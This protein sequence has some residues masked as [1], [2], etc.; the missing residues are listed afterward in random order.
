MKES[1]ENRLPEPNMRLYFLLLVV[2]AICAIPVNWVLGLVQGAAAA[3]L[4]VV[5][6]RDQHRRR[7]KVLQYIDS[8]TGTVNNASKSNLVH[9]PLP[10]M[11]FRPDTGDVI[12]SNEEFLTA[13]GLREQLFEK[14]I[15]SAVPGFPVQWL[16]EGKR[17]CPERVV[18]QGRRFRV[19]GNLVRSRNRSGE[20]SLA[21]TTYWIDVT[22]ADALRET[23]DATRPVL[24]ILVIDNYEDVMKA[25]PESQRSALLAQFE[26]Q[27]NKWAEG[28]LLLRTQRDRYLCLFDER[29][30]QRF[31]ADKFSVMDTIREIKTGDSVSPTLSIGVGKD[32]D[33]IPE[34]YKYANLSLEMAL[35]RGGDQTVVRNKVDFDFFG[36]RAR[37]TEKRTKVKSRVMA[38]A[39]AE[40]MSDAE[41]VYVMGHSYS[42]MD[43]VGAAA[44]VCCAARKRGK[45]PHIVIDEDHSAAKVLIDLLKPLPEYEGVFM[46]PD[47]A[48]LMLRPGSLLVVVDTNR[49]DMVEAPQVLEACNRVAVIDHHRRASVYIENAAL[50]YHEPYASSAAELVTDLLQYMVDPNE[51]LD[52]EAEAL[53][54]GIVLDTKHFSQRTGGRTFEAAAYLRRAGADTE[55][56]QRFFQ[57]GL[58]AMVRRYGI[59]RRAEVYRDGVAIAAVDDV[60]SDRVTAAQAADELL[61]LT[62][63][64]AS[65]VVYRVG[66]DVGLSARSL[67]DVNVQVILEKLGGGGNSTA[68]GGRVPDADVH[69]VLIR[70]R[71]AV[72]TYFAG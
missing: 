52:E 37:T 3:V 70:L 46:T 31:A 21:A 40:L 44:G 2:F 71:E 8:V 60:S 41:E 64:T 33:T 50:T 22:D 23:Y 6:V 7:G 32:A 56:V 24:A 34:L 55:T 42:D 66:E 63:I 68:A 11:V 14:K 67:G 45:K 57:N 72:D 17:E 29:D 58:D 25:C 30:Y 38:T 65:F 26:E 27:L 10:T 43:A 59:I 53:L 61:T 48:F 49:P 36:G 51:L 62:G 9:S 5:F 47:E 13:A 28:I 18:L 39:L 4:Y 15:E 16:L 1:I 54:A 69:D 35:S 19:Y 20:Q 12:W